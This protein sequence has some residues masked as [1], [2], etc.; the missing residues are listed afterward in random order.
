VIACFGLCCCTEY[1]LKL[2]F[3][4]VFYLEQ[5]GCQWKFV[6]TLLKETCQ[7]L[8]RLIVV[9][10]DNNTKQFIRLS[11]GDEQQRLLVMSLIEML[12]V[13]NRCGLVS[14]RLLLK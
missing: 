7:S 2:V 12:L 9:A 6:D 11:L 10:A 14:K 5:S 1:V 3:I 8:C 4:C 13:S